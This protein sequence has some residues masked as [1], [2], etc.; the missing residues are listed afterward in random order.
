MEELYIAYQGDGS[1]D[2]CTAFLVNK[3]AD[4]IERITDGMDILWKL[5]NGEFVAAN[6]KL[7][8]KREEHHCHNDSWGTKNETAVIVIEDSEY[9]TVTL[10][11]EGPV[12]LPETFEIT[13]NYFK[14]NGTFYCE[15]KMDIPV[16][17]K[18]YAIPDYVKAH[19]R[20]HE[21]IA[22]ITG[23]DHNVVP[24]LFLNT[25]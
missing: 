16:V 3:N 12:Y 25:K 23:P 19:L 4:K 1:N 13:V 14:P 11:A 15:D 22:V 17:I 6:I 24:H 5:K 20:L 8:S 21:M 2:D 9:G 10:D 7:T 18:P